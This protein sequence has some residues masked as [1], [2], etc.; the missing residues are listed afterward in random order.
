MRSI[1]G[2]LLFAA[3]SL[4]ALTYAARAQVPVFPGDAATCF[5][6]SFGPWTP[7]L[8]WRAS[9]HER[10]PESISVPRASGGRGWADE[11]TH[12]DQNGT[13]LIFPS[14]WPVGVKVAL[15][16]RALTPGDTVEGSAIALVGNGFVTP[17]RAAV[18]AWLVRCGAPRG[19]SSTHATTVAP[20]DRLP[21][22]TWRGTSTCL[23]S[24]VPCRSDSVV[25]R[26]AAIDSTSDGTSDSV[27]LAASTIGAHS[28]RLTSQLRCRYDAF[29]KILACD[30]SGSVLRLAVR[31]AELGGRLTRSDGV[32]LR[33]VYVRRE[34]ER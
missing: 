34:K 14:W 12:P 1:P 18:R 13:M 17:P 26:I 16:A 5:G 3:T 29:S 4:A 24:Q 32:D 11:L 8:D 27:S 31:G 19:E 28:E 22:G 33:Y 6:F 20:E 7:P 30:T 15:P 25:Y 2:F 21:I 23:R 10:T 9:G